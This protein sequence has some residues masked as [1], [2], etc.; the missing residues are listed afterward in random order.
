[1]EGRPLVTRV[2]LENYKSIAFCDVKL[3]PLAILVGP[4]GAGK[5]NFLDALRFLSEGMNRP[6]SKVFQDR[7]GF[8]NVLRRNSK[9]DTHLGF[10]AEFTTTH[11]VP[12]YYSVRFLQ[13]GEED[14]IVER[15]G[16]FLDQP[17]FNGFQRRYEISNL[18]ILLP[19]ASNQTLLTFAAA[20]NPPI[21]S[22]F[23]LFQGWHFYNFSPKDFRLPIP[24]GNGKPAL[25]G[26]GGNLANVVNHLFLQYPEVFARI[27]EYLRAIYP[28]LS[29]VEPV[30][31]RGYRTFDV[32]LRDNNGSFSPTQVSDGTL[33]VSCCT[34][35]LIPAFGR[36]SYSGFNW[37][38]RTRVGS[39]SRCGGRA[40]RCN[41]RGERVR[42]GHRH[43]P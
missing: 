14:Y 32:V 27:L 11:G 43:Y 9:T 40:L 30:E 20:T 24:A 1:M 33:R 38:R 37:Y 15:E 16:C 26:D 22:L 39:P 36:S 12:G 35:G 28:A 10:R 3:G 19:P 42:A 25:A 23:D 31:V 4:N 21:S 17:G 34:C 29:S 7:G 5:S 2:V 13:A 6:T 41:A 18:N 8:T